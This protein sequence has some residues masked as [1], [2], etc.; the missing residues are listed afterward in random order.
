M[1]NEELARRIA[2][3]VKTHIS[4]YFGEIP[5]ALNEA[6]SELDQIVLAELQRVGESP[7]GPRC[8][9]C[10]ADISASNYVLTVK[11][12][13]C[14]ALFPVN[15]IEDFRKFFPS[16]APA[17]DAPG[18][19]REERQRLMDEAVEALQTLYDE[20]ADYIHINHLGGVHHNQSMQQARNILTLLG[21]GELT[22]YAQTQSEAPDKR[23]D[24][25]L[26]SAYSITAE[27]K[28]LLWR[29]LIYLET[30]DGKASDYLA[31]DIRI[32][33]ENPHVA[34]GKNE[35]SKLSHE[36][37]DNIL[38]TI[39]DKALLAIPA[40]IGFTQGDLQEIADVARVALAR[41]RKGE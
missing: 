30:G 26:R 28:Q 23:I 18:L 39:K 41:L 27:A 40:A 12:P 4:Q 22:L 32:F 29:T 24:D 16:P 6:F 3:F 34:S 13:A 11:C 37:L 10:G 25:A 33:I 17:P 35:E 14:E 8:P 1:T 5:E 2:E 20:T 31:K 9:K 15:N 36:W 21:K 38:T 7:A 19:S